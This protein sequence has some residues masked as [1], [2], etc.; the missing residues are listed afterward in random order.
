MAAAA[1][2]LDKRQQ[3]RQQKEWLE[4]AVKTG[5]VAIV[6]ML[7]SR[8]P[9]IVAD[10]PNGFPCAYAFEQHN[11]PILEALL[12]AGADI[13]KEC[14]TEKNSG[15]NLILFGFNLFIHQGYSLFSRNWRGQAK[16]WY[17]RCMKM[18]LKLRSTDLEDKAGYNFALECVIKAICE[19]NPAPGLD[20]LL[21]RLLQAGADPNAAKEYFYMLVEHPRPDLIL[22]LRRYGADFSLAPKRDLF[23]VGQLRLSDFANQLFVFEAGGSKAQAFL[24]CKH[25]IVS[26]IAT[27]EII[28][29]QN[30]QQTFYYSPD[31]FNGIDDYKE[32]LLAHMLKLPLEEKVEALENASKG[33]NTNL[34]SRVFWFQRGWKK[35]TELNGIRIRIANE[36]IRAKLQLQLQTLPARAADAMRQLFESRLQAQSQA[37]QRLLA[38][39]FPQPHAEGKSEEKEVKLSPRESGVTDTPL[40]PAGSTTAKLYPL[41]SSRSEAPAP[42]S[43][44]ITPTAE[45]APAENPFAGS[46]HVVQAPQPSPEPTSTLTP[47][48]VPQNDGA[49]STTV[50]NAYVAEMPAVRVRDNPP[51]AYVAPKQEEKEA[52][53]VKL[54]S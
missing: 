19:P 8:F 42:A 40:Q 2:E 4:A 54:K 18:L 41:L 22:M 12:K 15:G 7:I 1:S 32:M 3:N 27:G 5:N 46:F 14:K 13:S 6:N 38:F 37:F 29:Y 9:S 53:R 51:P 36:L 28:Y 11:L 35:P 45:A 48:Y 39:E 16:N 24:S 25:A 49:M 20:Q 47:V 23:G 10:H 43:P 17:R 33:E 26:A 50:F 34:L 31:H 21:L 30:K 52:G 44:L